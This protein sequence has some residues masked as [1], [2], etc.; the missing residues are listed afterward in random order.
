VRPRRGGKHGQS[1]DERD[2][3]KGRSVAKIIRRVAEV[4]RDSVGDVAHGGPQLGGVTIAFVRL[5]GVAVV[6]HLAVSPAD[7][8]PSR[9]V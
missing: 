2:R 8:C 3:R 6:A 9:Q 1:F 5:A 4:M 7:A